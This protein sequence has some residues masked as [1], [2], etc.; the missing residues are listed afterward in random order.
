MPNA[1]LDKVGLNQGEGSRLPSP[2][3]VK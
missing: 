1:F 3:R 2:T